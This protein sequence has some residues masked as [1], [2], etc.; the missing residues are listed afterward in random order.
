M[1]TK[2]KIK[3]LKQ[4][5]PHHSIKGD[6]AKVELTAKELQDLLEFMERY[7]NST[8]MSFWYEE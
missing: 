2:Q 6:E 7:I 1:I 3:E 4:R 5:M 8:P